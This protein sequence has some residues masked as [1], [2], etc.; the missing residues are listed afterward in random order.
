MAQK[1]LKRGG[2]LKDSSMKHSRIRMDRGTLSVSLTNFKQSV[3]RNMARGR[4]P[5][6]RLKGWIGVGGSDDSIVWV[7]RVFIYISRQT[8]N[9]IEL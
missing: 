9:T 4:R 1:M 8:N 3:D 2:T 5:K 7:L 6:R